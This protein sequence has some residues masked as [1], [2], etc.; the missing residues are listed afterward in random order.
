MIIFIAYLA[1]GAYF[2]SMALARKFKLAFPYVKPLHIDDAYLG[3]VAR[4]LGI[5]P[6]LNQQIGYR[7]MQP[8]TL[9]CII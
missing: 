1:G 6:T 4:K 5:R 9:L 2:V 3:I 8:D 7:K